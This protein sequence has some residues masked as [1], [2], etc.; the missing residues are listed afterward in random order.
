PGN[1]KPYYIKNKGKLKGT[2]IRVGAT[3]KSADEEMI[4]ELERQKRNISFDEEIVY[5]CDLSN[6]DLSE[7]KKN[8]HRYTEK[9]LNEEN[10]INLK[11]IK[12]ENGKKHCTK[13]LILLTDNKFLD[14]AR[15]KCARFKGTDTSEFIDQKEF[16]SS[17][18]E[19]VENCM[20]FAKSHISKSGKI[21][22]LQRI[23]EYEVP[24]VAIREAVSNA[25][26]HRDYSISGADVKF[27]IFDDRIEI[28]SPGLLPKTLDIEDIK[29]GRSEIRNKVIARFF[30]EIRFIEE[31]GT[32]ISRIIKS[33]TEAGLEEPEF[34]ETGMFFKVIIKKKS[35]DKVAISSD[36]V[37]IS[38]DKIELND[39]ENKIIQ[40]LKEN[41]SITN[42]ESRVI[43]NIS[44][45]GVRK[46]FDSLVQKN[47][48]IPVGNKKSRYYIL[49]E[50]KQ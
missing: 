6:I 11:L 33:C 2:Y 20:T 46:V 25:V 47:L 44:S 26:V 31:W 36:K 27:A 3:N 50:N 37:S 35:S 8:F 32:G 5:D 12:E 22:E 13:A 23:D 34:I 14:Y 18:Y 9:E 29:M 42:K 24:L 16:S 45:S 30:K 4:M 40:Y 48:I 10:L 15:I 43:T 38:G 17:L 19:Q 28:T 21:T 39:S 1:L 7:L 49:N 41:E